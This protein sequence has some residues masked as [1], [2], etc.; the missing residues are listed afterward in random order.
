M[1]GDRRDEGVLLISYLSF[2]IG[3]DG[4]GEK[5]IELGGGGGM[6]GGPDKL[7]DDGVGKME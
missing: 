1:R 7:A 2:V 6:E 3:G 5:G 4:G